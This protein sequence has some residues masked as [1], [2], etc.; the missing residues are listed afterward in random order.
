M[1]CHVA[2]DSR[3]VF[4]SNPLHFLGEVADTREIEMPLMFLSENVQ[5]VAGS[6]FTH[7]PMNRSAFAGC[8]TADAAEVEETMKSKAAC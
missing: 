3:R 5:K 7:T 8:L 2:V 1:N 4:S 6:V